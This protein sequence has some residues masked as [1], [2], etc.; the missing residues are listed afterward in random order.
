M[1]STT[2][3]LSDRPTVLGGVTGH[4]DLEPWR[5][6]GLRREGPAPRAARWASASPGVAFFP[7]DRSL[8]ALP[9]PNRHV[10]RG[11]VELLVALVFGKITVRCQLLCGHDRFAIC[12]QKK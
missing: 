1:L 12:T 9:A 8:A 6:L 3:R 5:S 10:T 4:Y 11:D 2:V 7:P